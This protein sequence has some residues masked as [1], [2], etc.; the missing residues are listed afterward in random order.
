VPETFLVGRDGTIVQIEQQG[1]ALAKAIE[2]SLKA[3][4]PR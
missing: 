3:D 2:T 1:D 4:R